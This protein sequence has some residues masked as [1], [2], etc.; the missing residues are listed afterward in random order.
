MTA[1]ASGDSAGRRALVVGASRGIG[2]GLV[3]VLLRRGWLTTATV[4]DIENT[5]QA[6]SE[7]QK[8]YGAGLETIALDL[9]QSSRP[10]SLAESLGQQALDLLVISAGIMGP[11]HQ[12]A[13]FASPEAIGQLFDINAIAP[14]RIARALMP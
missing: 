10:H 5:P 2:L 4:R 7:L 9:A 13:E 12:R 14:V 3:Q 8:A 1:T 6:L 11:D